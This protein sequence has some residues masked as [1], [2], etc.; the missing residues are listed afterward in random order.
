[1]TWGHNADSR[2]AHPLRDS[3]PG[4]TSGDCGAG[5]PITPGEAQLCVMLSLGAP[6]PPAAVISGTKGT[7]GLLN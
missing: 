2:R 1:M 6:G 5:V 4:I 3:G 7:H